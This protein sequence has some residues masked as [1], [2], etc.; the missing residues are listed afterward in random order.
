MVVAGVVSVGDV[1]PE[2]VALGV[3]VG[4]PATA[5]AGAAVATVPCGIRTSVYRVPSAVFWSVTGL[6]TVSVIVGVPL[7]REPPTTETFA[8]VGESETSWN[9]GFND[10]NAPPLK[11][12]SETPL[13]AITADVGGA[14]G[15]AGGVAGAL[16]EPELVPPE[17][18]P[19]DEAPGPGPDADDDELGPAELNGS[20]LSKSENEPSWP[21]SAGGRTADTS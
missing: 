9:I 3:A 17:P 10:G 20:L 12:D 5:P 19:P 7:A 18:V 14:V 8:V 16:P 1:A 15:G 6:L 13:T 2:G 21:A 4:A 11:T